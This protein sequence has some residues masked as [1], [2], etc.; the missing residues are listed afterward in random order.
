MNVRQGGDDDDEVVRCQGFNWVV[1]LPGLCDQHLFV[2]ILSL[3][4]GRN[5]SLQ[6]LLIN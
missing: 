4:E 5:V 1:I 3:P 2:L 6:N